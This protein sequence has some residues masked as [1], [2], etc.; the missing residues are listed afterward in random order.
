MYMHA[1][2]VKNSDFSN[3]LVSTYSKWVKGAVG[4]GKWMSKW[5]DERVSERKG[6]CTYRESYESVGSFTTVQL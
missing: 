4:E 2:V 6:K 1:T 3:L 5:V